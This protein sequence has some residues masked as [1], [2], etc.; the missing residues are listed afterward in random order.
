[1]SANEILVSIII[2]VYNG[3][4]YLEESL[5]SC[6]QQTYQNIEILVVDDGSTDRT[7]RIVSDFEKNDNRI[8]YIFKENN[9]VASALNLGLTKI[10]GDYFTW[11]SHDDRFLPQKISS[12]VELAALVNEN[13]ILHCNYLIIDENGDYVSKVNVFEA[14]FLGFERNPLYSIYQST[15]N[16][17]CLF[18][19]K[20]IY[21]DKLFR[22]DE[23]LLTTQDYDL[24]HKIFSGIN[25][26]HTEEYLVETREHKNQSSKKILSV[27]EEND[28]L[29]ANF[30][31]NV[32]S[33]K[34]WIGPQDSKTILSHISNHLFNTKFTKAYNLSLKTL[35]TLILQDNLKYNFQGIYIIP[36]SNNQLRVSHSKASETTLDYVNKSC[37]KEILKIDLQLQNYML[38]LLSG[39]SLLIDMA[40]LE[41]R[42]KNNISISQHPNIEGILEKGASYYACSVKDELNKVT[43]HAVQEYICRTIFDDKKM[44]QIQCFCQDGSKLKT[45]VEENI[46]L[47]DTNKKIFLNNIIFSNKVEYLN[48]RIYKK[49]IKIKSLKYKIFLTIRL[50]FN[51]IYRRL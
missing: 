11:L 49:L 25:L 12:Q 50:V 4:N 31:R 8:Q 48:I 6:L 14:N 40:C 24:W 16:G 23:T 18:I 46:F 42:T 3:E 9:G 44:V 37:Q 20:K 36:V 33:E 28:I 21:K 29:W 19:P 51:Y 13:T 26:I 30:I 43:K 17:C 35:E 41:C 22:F 32:T 10:R 38:L 45:K 15:I 5:R 34:N 1:M 2:P 7:K 27:I 39:K 47:E